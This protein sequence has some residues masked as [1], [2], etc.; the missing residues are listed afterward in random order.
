MTNS[1][2]DQQFFSM[3]NQIEDIKCYLTYVVNLENMDNPIWKALIFD[4]LDNIHQEATESESRRRLGPLE[5]ELMDTLLEY[6]RS[7]M[8]QL[9]VEGING[10]FRSLGY[11]GYERGSF[12][13]RYRLEYLQR[14]R[15]GK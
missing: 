3:D 10:V 6:V 13:P 1:P 11:S 15:T 14:K 8:T 5:R 4:N 2:T 12:R 7:P 9:V